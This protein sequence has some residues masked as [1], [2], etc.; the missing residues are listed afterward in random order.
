MDK[1]KIQRRCVAERIQVR[2]NPDGTIGVRGYAAVFDSPAHGEVIRRHAFNRTLQQRD[3]VR[4]LVNHDGVPLARTSAGT[5]T[6]GVDDH[7][8]WFEAP[9]LDPANPRVQELVSAMRRGD[10]DQCS[11]SGY[12]E[13]RKANGLTEVVEVI[14]LDVS[15]VTY[16]W[17]ADT[18]AGLT[19]DRDSDRQL[20]S[21]RSASAD[22][23]TP[24]QRAA[25]VRAL[26]RMAPP[27]RESWSDITSCVWDALEERTGTWVYVC[28]IGDDWVVYRMWDGTEYEW[29]CLLQCSW[30]RDDA[31][32]V[33]LGDPFEV[34]AE[35]N[36]APATATSSTEA[37]TQDRT[38]EPPTEVRT[39]TIAEARALLAPAV[40]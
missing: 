3:D 18:S 35:F 38:D 21:V 5:L 2:D 36:P 17:Y 20:V 29:G 8:E 7:G 22:G 26:Q 37:G 39:F 28:E 11:F 34:V 27:G 30:S 1:S 4:L 23:L 6:L 31:G 12:F 33:T 32:V 10:I 16:P 15:I 14:Q 19:G 24:E 9:S 13:T 25:A 40:A